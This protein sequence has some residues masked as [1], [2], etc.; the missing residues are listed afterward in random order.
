MVCE[1]IV[2]RRQL[3]SHRRTHVIPTNQITCKLCY[4]VF[5]IKRKNRKGIRK[6]AANKGKILER[7]E[8]VLDS[9]NDKIDNTNRTGHAGHAEDEDFN[10]GKDQVD[11]NHEKFEED[12]MNYWMIEN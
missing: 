6:V 2:N 3:L 1:K 10:P 5:K 7:F 9:E 11:D 8:H 4:V 12:D